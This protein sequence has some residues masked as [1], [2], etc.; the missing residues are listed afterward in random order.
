MRSICPECGSEIPS[1]SEFCHH[2]GRIDTNRMR[3][4]DDGSLQQGDG[5]CGRCG[6]ALGPD[7]LFCRD[8][9]AIATVGCA[10]PFRPKLTRHGIVGI[11]LALIPGLFGIFGLGHL[12]FGRYGRAAMFLLVS[13]PL[14][15]LSFIDKAAD[16]SGTLVFLAR[17]FLYF[18]QTMEVMTLALIPRDMNRGKGD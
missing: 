12:W 15:Y 10:V 3:I 6:A 5:V 2:C 16:F 17:M 4:A 8:C 18:I 13:I 14:F 9:G 1:D 11:V 7:D